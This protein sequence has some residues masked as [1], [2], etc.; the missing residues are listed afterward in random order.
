[1]DYINDATK[2]TLT[3]YIVINLTLFL[4]MISDKLKAK[5]NKWRTKESTL[6]TLA[7][8]GG[9]VGGIIG[10]YLFRHKVNKA[11]FKRV[12]IISIFAHIMLINI[13]LS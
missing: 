7:I 9:G 12:Y 10:M 11:K 13:V 4:A 5:K 6:L 3:Y 8:A 1:M 2:V